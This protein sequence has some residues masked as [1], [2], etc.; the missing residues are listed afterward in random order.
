MTA[1]GEPFRHRERP[2][3]A[4]MRLIRLP[5]ADIAANRVERVIMTR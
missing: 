5:K 1:I 4:D 2:E 3:L